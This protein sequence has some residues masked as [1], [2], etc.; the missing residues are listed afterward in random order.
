MAW[1]SNRFRKKNNRRYGPNKKRYNRN[2]KFIKKRTKNVTIQ[3][4]FPVAG[5]RTIPDQLKVVLYARFAFTSPVAVGTGGNMASFNISGNWLNEP[6]AA[7]SGV[8]FIPYSAAIGGAGGG[9]AGTVNAGYSATA[10]PLFAN[11]FIPNMYTQYYVRGTQIKVNA[12]VS[13]LLDEGDIAVAPVPFGQ[14]N[15]T[16][17]SN[18]A[19]SRFAKSAEIGGSSFG[20]NRMSNSVSNYISTKVL[21]GHAVG[22]NYV[23]LDDGVVGGYSAG[24]ISNP[25]EPWMWQ[26]GYQRRLGGG[27]TTGQVTMLVQLKY[28]VTFLNPAKQAA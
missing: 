18:L 13:N 26:I 3:K 10:D 23:T 11:S 6:F 19:T 15:T 14:I 7:T 2:R 20:V 27:S 4:L 25:S 12:T 8:T 5:Q 17:M 21:N 28:Y 9:F 1:I 16:V 22:D 24:A